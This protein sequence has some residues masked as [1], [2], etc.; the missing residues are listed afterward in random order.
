MTKA[1]KYARLSPEGLVLEVFV[2][3]D[4]S[5]G[6][7]VEPSDVFPEAL[8]AQFVACPKATQP[9]DHIRDGKLVPAPAPPAPLLPLLSATAFYLAFTPAERIAI[10][11]SDDVMVQEFWETFEMLRAAKS[12]I[13]PNLSSVRDGLAYLHSLGVISSPERIDQ[14]RTGVPQ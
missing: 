14:I 7:R 5:T 9:N 13:D 3:I 8:A 6:K 10:K 2:P 4:E 11:T 12:L 1:A